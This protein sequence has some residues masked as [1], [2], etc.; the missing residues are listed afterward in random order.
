MTAFLSHTGEN[1]HI[2]LNT[3]VTRVIPIRPNTNEFRVVE[4]GSEAESQ[5]KKI[6]AEKEVIVS[7]GVIGTPHILL[8]SGIGDKEELEAVGVKTLVNNP[9]VGKNLSDHVSVATLF[10]TSMPKT[11]CDVL[12][13][14]VDSTCSSISFSFDQDAA[15]KEWN[16]TRTGPLS[17]PFQ[18]D[19][20][21]FVR[22]PKNAPPFRKE[23]FQ[24]P[25]PPKGSAHI[26]F[27]FH[28]IGDLGQGSTDGRSGLQ[29][30]V[31]NLHPFS[32]EYP[33]IAQRLSSHITEAAL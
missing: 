25:S 7:G 11:R 8:H 17:R 27:S 31:V 28:M 33:C 15:L 30:D 6:I 23:G 1:V 16:T 13:H 3:Q 22:L 2:L 10:S 24:D 9:S 18:M 19:H 32:R 29:A 5:R 4:V 26:E 14:A 12:S 21:T 20:L